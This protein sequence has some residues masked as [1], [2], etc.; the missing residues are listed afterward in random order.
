MFSLKIV[1]YTRFFLL[2]FTLTW[3]TFLT[4]RG[5]LSKSYSVVGWL[6]HQ[7][8]ETALGLINL[9]IGLLGC[10]NSFRVCKFISI[11]VLRVYVDPR[12]KFGQLPG[13]V[14]S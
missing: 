7:I 5:T 1:D 13:V 4:L 11:I 8:L 2:L 3:D 10:F 12:V 6:A 9:G 14:L